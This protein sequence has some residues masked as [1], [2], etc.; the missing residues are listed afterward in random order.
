MHN[1]DQMT[2][3]TSE[4]KFKKCCELLKVHYKYILLILFMDEKRKLLLESAEMNILKIRKK[5]PFHQTIS[6][7]SEKVTCRPQTGI[8][9]YKDT[10]NENRGPLGFKDFFS[11]TYHLG[12]VQ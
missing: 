6:F 7:P 11:S 10:E 9:K 3:E 4:K 1:T 2:K 5:G 12:A 8:H